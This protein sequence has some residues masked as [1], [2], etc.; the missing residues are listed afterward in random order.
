MRFISTVR[1]DWSRHR[2]RCWPMRLSRCESITSGPPEYRFQCRSI[3]LWHP[4]E[5]ELG[6]GTDQRPAGKRERLGSEVA[7][8]TTP[9]TTS[10]QNPESEVNPGALVQERSSAMERRSASEGEEKKKEVPSR[11]KLLQFAGKMRANGL[12]GNLLNI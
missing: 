5:V 2:D 8:P 10:A 12:G 3:G 1:V 4:A 9:F 7:C 6:C 11:G